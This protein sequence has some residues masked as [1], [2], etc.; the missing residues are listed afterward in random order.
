M[1][2]SSNFFLVMATVRL[3]PIDTSL[4]NDK[5]PEGEHVV[6]IAMLPPVLASMEVV[7]WI[8]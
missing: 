8:S 1:N 5:H 3:T 7:V 4:T 2:Q 6:A